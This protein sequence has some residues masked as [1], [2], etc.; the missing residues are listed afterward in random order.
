LDVCAARPEYVFAGQSVHKADPILALN[1]PAM[2]ASQPASFEPVYPKL[3]RHM[4]ALLLPA[5]DTALAEHEMQVALD[6]AAV[7][8]EYEFCRQS[9]HGSAPGSALCFPAWHAL[10]GR[11]SWPVTCEWYPARHLQSL[12]RTLLPGANVLLGQMSH[13]A[14][15]AAEYVSSAHSV[16]CSSDTAPGVNDSYPAPHMEHVVAPSCALNDPALQISHVAF[17]APRSFVRNPLRQ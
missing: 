3:H 2:H 13:C 17:A 11:P 5:I 14:A 15:P 16:H 9:V 4:L 12:S 7:S 1:F 10:H 6:V 8:V